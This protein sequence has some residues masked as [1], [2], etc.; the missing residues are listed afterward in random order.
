MGDAEQ[1]RLRMEQLLS[2]D[3]K[4][5]LNSFSEPWLNELIPRVDRMMGCGQGSVQHLE[6]DVAVH[7]ALVFENLLQITPLRVQRE[8]DFVER[9]SVLLHDLRKPDVS[10]ARS[11]GAVSFPGHEA[12]AAAEVPSIAA[13]I[14]LN[15]QEAARLQFL[16][17]RHGDAHSWSK[18]TP[19]VRDELRSSP[20]AVS[21]ALLQEADARSCLFP[22][23]SHLPIFW[24]EITGAHA[25]E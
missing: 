3:R 8:A 18:L 24:S 10:Q 4:G 1:S 9:L 17:A 12:L 21:L 2:L 6:G 16:V 5:F 15:A 19:A 11:D 7:T 23:G 20:Y 14:G 25:N 13:R 22:D